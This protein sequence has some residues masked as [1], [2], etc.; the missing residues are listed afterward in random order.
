[1]A[2]SRFKANHSISSLSLHLHLIAITLLGTLA[3]PSAAQDSPQDY[4]DAHN[5][6]RFAVGVD[7]VTWDDMV[8]SYAQSYAIQ[9]SAGE[10]EL[11]HSGGPYGE[12][13]AWRI[14]ELSGT[15]SVALWVN[16]KV[17]YD[18]DT[19]TCTSIGPPG[20]GHYTQVVWRR[21]TT[22]GCAKAACSSGYGTFV[23]CSY[24]PRGNIIGQKP[25]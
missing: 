22:I 25:Y 15:E 4:L 13:L 17:D 20:C 18:Y 12:N 16:E 8:A 6:A 2:L 1:M 5:D 7:P 3:I 11:V 14:G 19:N 23:V 21:T 9:R 24:S 10:C